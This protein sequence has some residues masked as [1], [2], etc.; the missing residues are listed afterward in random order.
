MHFLEKGAPIQ[1]NPEG[2]LS[3]LYCGD[4]QCDGHGGY[5]E[6]VRDHSRL[7]VILEGKGLFHLGGGTHELTA[8][9]IFLVSPGITSSLKPCS[10]KRC[11]Y[12][13]IAFQGRQASSI[14]ARAGFGREYP[15]RRGSTVRPLETHYRKL[16]EAC[17]SKLDGDLRTTAG[18]YEFLA[19][20]ISQ[21]PQARQRP[22]QQGQLAKLAA[23]WLEKNHARRI[24]V[25]ELTG[26]TGLNG[27]YF[28]RLFRRTHGVSPQQYLIDYRM[29][30]AKNLLKNPGLSVS[31]V[32]HSVGYE[33]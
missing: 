5:P 18:L 6:C 8:G 12:F 10:G 11:S 24:T 30:R 25:G 31:S 23:L 16:V 4:T 9:D 19:A 29:E 1:Q 7:Y 27:K 17:S 15:V 21:A 22:P 28:S 32:A 13:W 2:E 20:L 33:D 3:F 14:L 26:L